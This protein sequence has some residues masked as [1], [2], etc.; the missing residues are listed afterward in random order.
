[1]G[2]GGGGRIASS[3]TLPDLDLLPHLTCSR[4]RASVG[5]DMGQISMA[6]RDELVVA[7]AGRYTSSNRRSE[8]ASWMNS[9]R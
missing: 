3:E 7:L 9:R 6:T 1:M 2:V 8:A 4:R 5:A